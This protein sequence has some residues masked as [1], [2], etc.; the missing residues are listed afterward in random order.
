MENVCKILA[1]KY[2]SPAMKVVNVTISTNILVVSNPGG[3][4][5]DMNP[6]E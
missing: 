4:V 6:E 1:E 5:P 2:H 3:T